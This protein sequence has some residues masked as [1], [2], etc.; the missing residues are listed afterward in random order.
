MRV[1]FGRRFSS[2]SL[3]H[4]HHPGERARAP[5]PPEARRLLHHRRHG[6]AG[7]YGLSGDRLAKLVRAPYAGPPDGDGDDDHQQLCEYRVGP[8]GL[9]RVGRLNGFTAVGL[10]RRAL[11]IGGRRRRVFGGGFAVTCPLL[12]LSAPADHAAPASL[13]GRFRPIGNKK[14]VVVS[15]TLRRNRRKKKKKRRKCTRR[16]DASH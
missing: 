3:A 6:F 9:A 5:L 7:G 11:V 13:C 2:I 10:V 15:E 8:I 16:V 14:E 1:A 12:F 4:A